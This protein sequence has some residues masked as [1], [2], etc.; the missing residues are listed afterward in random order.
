MKLKTKLMFV[1]LAVMWLG[2]SGKLG[3]VRA[4]PSEC[5]LD[6]D[7]GDPNQWDC[8]IIPPNWEAQCVPQ[9]NPSC[10]CGDYFDYGV[11][12]WSENFCSYGEEATHLYCLETGGGCYLWAEC[13]WMSN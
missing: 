12:W 5:F 13:G 8:L 7:C 4:A 2:V 11:E 9:D 10:D 3:T 1:L 6:I